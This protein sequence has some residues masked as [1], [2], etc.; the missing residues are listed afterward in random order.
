MNHHDLWLQ[1]FLQTAPIKTQFIQYLQANPG[2]DPISCLKL[3][4]KR[5]KA[6][7]PDEITYLMAWCAEDGQGLI[8]FPSLPLTLKSIGDPPVLLFYQGA[9]MILDYNMLAVV[10]SRKPSPA[11]MENT[12]Y[13]VR[14]FNHPRLA[15]ISGLAQGIDTLAHK[16]A[17]TAK[18][19]TVAVLGCGLNQCYPKA[20][21][22]L[23]AEIRDKGLLLSE[24]HPNEGVKAWHF[25]KRNRLISGLSEGILVVEAAMK[26][27]SLTT[28]KLAAEQGRQVMAVPGDI[29][30]PMVQG[31]HL[32]IREGALMVTSP[33]EVTEA[34]AWLDVKSE[35][36]HSAVELLNQQEKRLLKVLDRSPKLV[37]D[38]IHYSGM[39]LALVLDLLFSLELRGII[40]S[41]IDG[42]Y[43][44]SRGQIDL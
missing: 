43:K 37:D 21:R 39:E 3:W 29:H 16:A 26:S 12:D 23:Q 11:G 36:K 10:G 31:C 2:K 27:G 35:T 44:P 9:S 25:P 18:L 33:A 30:N 13:F 41:S 32:L 40:V 38:I 6:V 8:P 17:I 5:C 19:A 4:L 22:F 34:I 1:M 20:N 15:I 42:Y 14:H 28:A 24:F 7:N